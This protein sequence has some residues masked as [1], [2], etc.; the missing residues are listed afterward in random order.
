MCEDVRTG[1]PMREPREHTVATAS[2]GKYSCERR[3]RAL[4]NRMVRRKGF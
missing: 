2:E 1:A 4:G 3:V